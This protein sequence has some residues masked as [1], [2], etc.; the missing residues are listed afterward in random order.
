MTV[1]AQH[2]YTVP[3]QW[4]RIFTAVGVAVALTVAARATHLPLLPSLLLVAV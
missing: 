2:V 1:Y 4:R 3:Y